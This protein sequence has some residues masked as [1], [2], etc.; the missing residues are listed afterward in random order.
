MHTPVTY[1]HKSD[2]VPSNIPAAHI[3]LVTPATSSL[4]PLPFPG[5]SPLT[6]PQCELGQGTSTRSLFLIPHRTQNES[7]RT[8]MVFYS[9]TVAPETLMLSGLVKRVCLKHTPRH[10]LLS[11]HVYPEAF[12]TPLH[13]PPD[14]F[15]PCS[16]H[17]PNFPLLSSPHGVYCA[18]VTAGRGLGRRSTLTNYGYLLF[19]IV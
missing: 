5:L 3:L 16:H 7:Q 18:M 10:H 19:P 1:T 4:L 15:S 11:S 2:S 12:P 9:P 14:Q 6:P 13:S 8:V 17:A